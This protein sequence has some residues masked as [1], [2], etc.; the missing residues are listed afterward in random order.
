MDLRKKQLIQNNRICML[1][2]VV[3]QVLMLGAT[4][5]YKSKRLLPTA[6]IVI[7]ILLSIGISV[8]GFLK[9]RHEHM[10]HLF[11]LGSLG[12]SYMALLLGS[13]H[14][15][16]FWAFGVLIGI[17]VV[18]YNSKKIC[19]LACITAV[20]EN[21]IYV[22]LFYATGSNVKF[23]GSTHMVPTNMGFVVIFAIVCYL[24]VGTNEK[25]NEEVIDDINAK[26]EEQA[27]SAEVIRV[28]SERIAERL[29]AAGE[30]MA[31]L[32]EK[33]H[34]S[35]EAVDQISSSVSMTAEAIQVQTEM[36]SNIVSSLESIEGESKEMENLS[37]IVKTNVSEGNKIIN[38]L[39]KQATE[40]AKVNAVTAE[41]TNELAQ[42]AETVKEIVSAILS[43]S[44][45]TN[46]L[47]LNASI[48]AARAGEAGKGF[49]VVA[50]EI[51]K[52]SEDTKQSAEEI[53]STIE[54]LISSVHS[55]SSN[56]QQSVESSNRQ[57]ELI[58]ETGKKFEM[59]LESVN[60]LAANVEEISANVESCARATTKVMESITDLSATSEEVAASSES[61]L[62]L[63]YECEKDMTE[64]N[65]ILD[66]ILK[67]SR[68]EI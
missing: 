57:G 32:S 7:V 22:I 59:I 62:T 15:P 25:Q 10:A 46:L 47:A 8:F 43:I 23:T 67:I 2:G 42:S 49:A 31:N 24:V 3:I 41:M 26:A 38:E 5:G 29:E 12:I 13:L 39:Q 34:S 44:S 28:T 21:A 50:D 56:M 20:I 36:N 54:T 51:R 68:H 4:I 33:V 16:Y 17:D 48:E 64:T 27:K 65:D 9:W 11:I 60:A 58:E 61:S 35:T 19:M 52:L 66:E 63:S 14:T 37:D 6:P 55:A 45:Q 30:S 1:V 18:I 40:T 53:G